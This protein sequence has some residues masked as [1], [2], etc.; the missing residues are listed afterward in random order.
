M[1]GANPNTEWLQGCVSLDSRGF[2]KTGADL[3]TRDLETARWPLRR[4]PYLFETTVPGVFAVG[5][6]PFG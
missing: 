6:R 3:T 1:T 2:A 5:D 4:R